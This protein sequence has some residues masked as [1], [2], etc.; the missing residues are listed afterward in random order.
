MCTNFVVIGNDH[1]SK[2]RIHVLVHPKA[3]DPGIPERAHCAS[4]D[5]YAKSLRCVLDQRYAAI[6]A[7]FRDPLD[8]AGEAIKVSHD[9]GPGFGVNQALY[10]R[11]VNVACLTMDVSKHRHSA[12]ADHHV[13]NIGDRVRRHDYLLAGLD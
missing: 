8:I 12:G 11:S 9:H 3:V 4:I 13:N 6:L 2:E 5:A 7:D 1:S 10:L